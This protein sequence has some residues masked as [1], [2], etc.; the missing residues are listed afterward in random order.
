MEIFRSIL[1][2]IPPKLHDCGKRYALICCDS[3]DRASAA[4]AETP[5]HQGMHYSAILLSCLSGCLYSF[6]PFISDVGE[7]S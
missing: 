2:D 5:T 4:R 6:S 3:L 7:A 1:I